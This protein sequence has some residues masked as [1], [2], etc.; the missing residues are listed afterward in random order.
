M[1]KYICC[2]M[3]LL[4]LVLSG[5]GF[6]AIKLM[7][8]EGSFP[9]TVEL[10]R[11]GTMLIDVDTSAVECTWQHETFWGDVCSVSVSRSEEGHSLLR[12]TGLRAGVETLE[13]LCVKEGSEAEKFFRLSV[14]VVVDEKNAVSLTD[15]SHRSLSG[16]G[17]GGA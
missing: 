4:M 8:E 16:S 9:Y 1:K 10:Q 5:C 2:A 7:E 3:A 12:V 15:Y 6:G 13:F 14:D 17:S 11:N